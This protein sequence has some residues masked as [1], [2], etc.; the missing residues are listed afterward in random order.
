MGL[1]TLSPQRMDW[2]KISEKYIAECQGLTVEEKLISELP[3]PILPKRYHGYGFDN[4]YGAP[5]LVEDLKK[6]MAS[7]ANIILSGPTGSGKTHLAV[8]CLREFKTTDGALFIT[9]PELLMKARGTFRENSDTTEE[10]LINTY[11]SRQLLCLDDLGAEKNSD[12]AITTLYLIIDKRIAEC[13]QTIIT[14]NLTLQEIDA[15][16]GARIA[17]R[18]SSMENIKIN[19]PDYRKRRGTK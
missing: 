2:N 15:S 7:K 4:F 17:S 16:F 14:T 1:H 3:I 12:Y 5:K 9:V 6:H 19:M 13:R 10:T 18:L 8:A 11:T